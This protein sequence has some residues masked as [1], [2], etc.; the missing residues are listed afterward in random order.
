MEFNYFLVLGTGLI[1]ALVAMFCICLL[2]YQMRLICRNLS[3]IDSLQERRP[4]FDF[5]VE[6][7]LLSR[8]ERK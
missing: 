4:S 8:M 1:V 2:L 7:D 5:A 3:H 6:I